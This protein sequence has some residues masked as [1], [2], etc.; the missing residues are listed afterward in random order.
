MLQ[1]GIIVFF[2]FGA[3]FRAAKEYQQNGFAWGGIGLLAFYIPSF[4]VPF[5]GVMLLT[6]FGADVRTAAGSL[7]LI[8]ILGFVAGV[9]SVIMVYNKLMDRAIAAQ[10]LNDE[11]M[12][13]RPDAE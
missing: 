6:L 10:I 13:V 7:S 5:V 12:S 9:A 3:F 11:R 4:V 1:N 2:V 8:G